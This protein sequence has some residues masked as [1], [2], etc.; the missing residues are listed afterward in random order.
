MLRY[1]A[2]QEDKT[3]T[4]GIEEKSQKRYKKHTIYGKVERNF[5]QGSKGKPFCVKEMKVIL[6]W[7][8]KFCLIILSLLDWFKVLFSETERQMNQILVCFINSFLTE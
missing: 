6:L 3:T 2:E 5:R 7:F 8:S 4:E 1:S